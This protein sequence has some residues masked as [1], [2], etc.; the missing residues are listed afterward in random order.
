MIEE[1]PAEKSID[2]GIDSVNKEDIA[3]DRL[4]K[5]VLENKS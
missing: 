3:I 2:E 5:M 1:P 4:L